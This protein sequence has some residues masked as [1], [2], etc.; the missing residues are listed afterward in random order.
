[1]KILQGHAIE[2]SK[3]LVMPMEEKLVLPALNKEIS[4]DLHLVQQYSLA[5]ESLMYATVYSCLDVA[6]AVF[7][8]SQYGLN[9]K[10]VYQKAVKRI[11]QYLKGT[12]NYSLTF[13]G[14]SSIMSLMSYTNLNWAGNKES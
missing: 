3:P 5:I 13:G 12:L 9:S 6:Y 8:L 7:K 10:K 1:M 14:T 11:L 4:V 2:N